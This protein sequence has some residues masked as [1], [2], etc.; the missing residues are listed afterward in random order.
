MAQQIH[1]CI[2]QDFQSHVKES[3]KELRYDEDFSD[4]ILV[5]EDSRLYAH[6]VVLS[7]ASTVFKRMFKQ[8][9]HQIPLIVYLRKVKAKELQAILDFIYVGEAS[10]LNQDLQQFRSYTQIT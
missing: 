6:Q 9:R 10:V 3:F 5:C 7:T 8:C 4:V 1:R 2:Q